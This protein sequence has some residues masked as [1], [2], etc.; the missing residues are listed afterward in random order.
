[1]TTAL[2][3]LRASYE[4]AFDDYL[5]SRSEDALHV[6]YELGRAAVSARMSILDLSGT[7]HDVLSSALRRSRPHELEWVT[8]AAAN[9]FLQALSAFEMVQR[10]FREAQ[11]SILRE[12]QHTAQLHQLTE[13]SVAINSA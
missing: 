9:F 6:A 8:Q 4:K 2:L 11:Q 5:A 1:M 10:G 12:K 7:H 13:A 3:S